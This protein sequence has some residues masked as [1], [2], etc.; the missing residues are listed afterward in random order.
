MTLLALSNEGIS[1]RAVADLSQ[2]TY[3]H[4]FVNFRYSK[5][6][7]VYSAKLCGRRRTGRVCV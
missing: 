7:L 3:L 5:Y 1:W 2:I 4:V 6:T